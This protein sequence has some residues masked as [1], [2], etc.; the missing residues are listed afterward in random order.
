MDCLNIGD[1]VTSNIY[2]LFNKK[3]KIVD[4]TNNNN[5]EKIAVVDFEG[6]IMNHELRRLKKKQ[7]G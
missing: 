3:G 2:I 6:T 4:F 1:L 7:L 5:G